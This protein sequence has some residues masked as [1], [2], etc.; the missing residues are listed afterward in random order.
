MHDACMATTTISISDAAYE[1]LSKLKG[2]DQSFSDVILE[3]I[4]DPP[5]VNCGQL[6][7]QLQQLK[8]QPLA[9][10]ARMKKMLEGRGRRS[11]RRPT[12]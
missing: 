4:A 10:P 2:P 8:G 3:Q 12:K 5:A 1:R 7:E 6:L 11:N 9:N